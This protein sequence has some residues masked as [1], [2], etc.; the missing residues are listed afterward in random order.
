[1]G[2][3]VNGANRMLRG[4]SDVRT[5]DGDAY[6]IAHLT[7]VLALPGAATR[8]GPLAD[9]VGSIATVVYG[10]RERLST[11]GLALAARA[12]ADLGRRAEA[13]TCLDLLMTR[14]EK[15]GAGLHWPSASDGGWFGDDIE[16][17]AYA[18][19]AMMAITPEDPRAAEVMTWLAGRRSGGYWR[20]TRTTG[21]A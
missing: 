3:I 5:E 21:P 13:R 11:S 15:D 16:T 10:S 17:T 8:F 7:S 1:D 2:A 20:S 9:Q 14:A 12:L 18:L 19:S 6:V 4:L